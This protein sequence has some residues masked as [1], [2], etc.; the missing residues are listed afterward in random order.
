MSIALILACVV[1]W[2]GV[3]HAT[4]LK[5]IDDCGMDEKLARYLGVAWPLVW[6]LWGFILFCCWAFLD[7]ED[8]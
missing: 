5:L 1:F 8:K 3:A 2:F 6:G 4:E 7:G